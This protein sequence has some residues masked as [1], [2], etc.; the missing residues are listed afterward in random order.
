MSTSGSSD[1]LPASPGSCKNSEENWAA[2]GSPSPQPMASSPDLL[3]IPSQCASELVWAV[4]QLLTHSDCRDTTCAYQVNFP[5]PLPACSYNLPAT[6]SNRRHGGAGRVCRQIFLT[7]V[8]CIFAL[9]TSPSWM[10]SWGRYF[11]G[12]LASLPTGN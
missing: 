5:A 8:D 11:F 1:R 12:C 10:L 2:A 7:S 9:E 3:P 4:L 6:I